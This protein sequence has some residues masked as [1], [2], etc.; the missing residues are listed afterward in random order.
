MAK[1]SE[2]SFLWLKNAI[3]LNFLWLKIRNLSIGVVLVSIWCRF[4]VGLGSAWGFVSG[5][6]RGRA[7]RFTGWLGGSVW[8]GA[9]LGC[10]A[11]GS[12]PCPNSVGLPTALLGKR[13]CRT[14][15]RLH[16]HPFC[17]FFCGLHGLVRGVVG[18]CFSPF[19]TPLFFHEGQNITFVVSQ[20]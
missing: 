20:T 18:V 16:F 19:L 1:N 12:Q 5:K 6:S 8:F 10:C 11:R 2:I 9:V 17:W 3:S 7:G 15:A 14:H 13:L 4:G